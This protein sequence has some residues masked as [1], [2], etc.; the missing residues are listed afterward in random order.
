MSASGQPGNT[1]VGTSMSPSY[2][3]N[4]T[5][6]AGSK[7]EGMGALQEDKLNALGQYYAANPGAATWSNPNPNYTW[8]NPNGPSRPPAAGNIFSPTPNTQTYS[9]DRYNNYLASNP[10]G[11]VPTFDQWQANA[12]PSTADTPALVS[13][14]YNYLQPGYTPPSTTSTSGSWSGAPPPNVSVTPNSAGNIPTPIKAR[15]RGGVTGKSSTGWIPDG[16]S[17]KVPGVDH[18]HDEIHILAEPGEV[19]FNKKQLRGLKVGRGQHLR[20]DQ[21]KAIREAQRAA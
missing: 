10:S 19:V 14:Y 17:G 7:G 4:G 2:Q 5:M 11:V 13:A 6:F 9:F 21:K 1:A 16:W 12:P 20:A 15:A 18:G 8:Q 3:A